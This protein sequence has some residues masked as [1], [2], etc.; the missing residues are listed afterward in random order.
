MTAQGPTFSIVI[1][2]DGRAAALATTLQSLRHL[3]A[4]PFEVV[5]VRG[6]TEDGIEDVLASWRG[7]VKVARNPE[8][9]LSIA[10]N[11]G[12]AAA[13][14]DVV[15]FLDDDAIPEP[16]WLGELAAAYGDPAVGGA[17]G[18]VL[19]PDGITY[20]YRYGVVDRLG[21]ADL[22]WSR[23]AP[24]LCFPF[25]ASFPHPLGANSSFRR[26]ALI[27]LGGFD[28]EF[29]YYLDETDMTA[30]LV[31][32]GWKMAQIGGA[33][34]HHKYMA[35]ANRNEARV[36]T[37][38]YAII[39]NHI[40]FGLRHGLAYHSLNSV[41][42]AAQSFIGRMY[43]DLDWAIGA[44]KLTERDR[45]RFWTEVDEAWRDGLARGLA[46]RARLPSAA[47]LSSPEPF[48]PF[49]IIEPAGRRRCF[50]LLSQDYPP[51]LVGGI[52]RYTHTLARGLAALGHQVHVLTRSKAG[53][54]VDFEE[55]VWVH[56]LL[57]ATE[58]ESRAAQ[59]DVPLHIGAHSQRM[60]R[61]VDAI[62]ARRRVDAVYAP[63][64]DCEGM[65]FLN[66]GGPPFVVSLQTTL[67][68]W[69]ESKPE[70]W[71]DPAFARD[72][73]QP[74]LAMEGRLMK[75]ADGVHA[76]SSAI[77]REI[78]RAYPLTFSLERLNVW[79]LGLEDWTVLPY[80]PPPPL[81]DGELRLLF[82]G[83]LESRKGIDILLAAA[84]PVLERHA[85]VHLDLVGDHGIAGPDGRTYRAA[86][87]TDPAMR[88]IAR[89]VRFH[90]A[91][92]EE[93]LRGF[94]R[95][96][97]VLVTPSRFESFGLMLVEG[98][99]FGKPVIGCR[100][101]GMVEIVEEGVTG[102]LAVP[103]DATSLEDCIDR[104]VVDAGLRHSLGLAGR[105]RYE[106]RFTAESMAAGVTALLIAVAD[107]P[108]AKAAA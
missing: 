49:Q 21:R 31:D 72:F 65:A 99:M 88:A 91:V 54:S 75:E 3:D 42:V 94:Y 35:S 82:V 77:A 68:F 33:H 60:R 18:F 50:C 86:F 17:G 61:E 5:V 38:W 93:R 73:I 85:H 56:R 9:N 1:C 52:G 79:P 14:G 47:A 39:K 19:N 71:T 106:D 23:A 46:G 63:V 92:S 69:L 98:M 2:T 13:A 12:I 70:A 108:A 20:Q 64:W 30:R 16:E 105:Q 15:A 78:E 25:T 53:E 59:W 103:G 96:C 36:L 87:E 22:S 55:G 32:A 100:A 7:Q 11:L 76:I 81:T 90:G 10:R 89:R 107:A 57:P 48:L 26:A 44:G 24:E 45:A 28:E 6:P 41:I 8:R 66:K 40:Y 97:D 84:K 58:D 51:G 83:R 62:G 34:V 102:L 74:M 37:H 95:A 67:H 27:E 101:G 29:E 80:D 104:L 4:P 43:N